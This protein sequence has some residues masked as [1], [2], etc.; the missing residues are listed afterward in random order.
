MNDQSPTAY[1]R[2]KDIDT[3]ASLSQRIAWRLET[4]AWDVIY[5]APMKA[6]GPDRA[7]DVCGWLLR[8]IGP[9]FSQHKTMTRNLRLAFPDWSAEEVARTALDAWESAGRT[10]G[11]LPHLPKIDTGPSGRVEVV[12]AE[13]LD[14]IRE[15]GKGAVFFSGHFANWEIMPAVITQ[16]MPEAVM[17]YRALNNPHID[18]RVSDVR[19]AYGTQ[20]NAPKGIGTRELMRA[21]S[22]GAPVALMN[23][24]KFNSGIPAKFFGH[25]AMTAPGPTRLALKYG[26]PL[27]PVSTERTGPA[28]FRV[29]FH[30]PFIPEDTGDP[31]A[32]VQRTV[33]R[34]NAFLE[35]HVRAVPGQWFWQHRRWPKEAWREAGVM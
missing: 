6:L 34:I 9:L 21:L 35:A 24:Q 14:R 30:E 16:R 12:G 19:H 15:S 32:D 10:A 7:S 26:V 2:P 33:D 23:D 18:R 4:I 22:R 5:W 8:R 11:E 27:V 29:V 20:V 1:V 3:R 31:E 13:V 25:D 17:T 28:R